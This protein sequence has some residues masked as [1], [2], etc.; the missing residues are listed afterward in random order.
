MYTI[1][2][3]VVFSALLSV[4]SA[5]LFSRAVNDPAAEYIERV[6]QP[7]YFYAIHNLGSKTLPNPA[8]SPYPCDQS[9]YIESICTAN[10]TSEINFLAEQQCLCNGSFWEVKEACDACYFAHGYQQIS[11]GG[12]SSTRSSLKTAE[13]SPSLLSSRTRICCQPSTSP[14]LN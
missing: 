14:P 1:H 5:K 3:S 9:Q 2:L 11:P 13:C 8:N 12:A 4:A 10:G 7:F 6:C